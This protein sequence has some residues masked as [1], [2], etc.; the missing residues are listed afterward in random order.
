MARKSAVRRKRQFQVLTALLVLAVIVVFGR[1]V[2]RAAHDSRS[3][4]ESRNTSFATLA[5]AIISSSSSLDHDTISLLDSAPSMSRSTLLTSWTELEKRARDVLQSAEHARE[6]SIET[7]INEK[8]TSVMTLRIAAWETIRQSVEGPLGVPGVTTP[9]SGVLNQAVANLQTANTAWERA[10]GALRHRPGHVRLP[11]GAWTLPTL[12]VPGLVHAAITTL[13]LRPNAIVAINAVSMNPQPLPSGSAGATALVLL[14]TS[15]VEL[16]VSVRNSST[17]DTTITVHAT[18]TPTNRLGKV[19]TLS[20]TS[21][22]RASSNTAV[23][24]SEV[25]ITPGERAILRVWV[26]G[27]A[28]T[29]KGAANRIY[30]V[31]VA[32]AG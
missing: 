30:T 31:K 19:V 25:P 10:H 3:A 28:P 11:L 15:S 4:R 24:F 8:L 12:D 13:A 23:L 2:L 26:S 27:A 6:P 21:S 18:L 9:P 22:L 14:P 16:G 17:T 5:T 20:A 29:S 7:G 32:S 1:D